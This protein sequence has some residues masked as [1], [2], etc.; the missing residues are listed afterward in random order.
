[1]KRFYRVVDVVT[2]DR[3]FAVTLDGRTVRTPGKLDFAVPH[4]RLAEAVAAEWRRQGERV[5]IGAM[6]LTRFANTA[7][8]LVSGR[9]EEVIRQIAAYAET[10]LVCYRAASPPELVRRQA[11]AWDPLLD[12]L[13]ER[14]GARLAT[15]AGVAPGRQDAP[16]LL[17]VT[18][19]IAGF[20]SFPL[21]AL[22]V[23]ATACGSAVV[24]LAL[25]AGRLDAG[26][27]FAAAHVD[28]AWQAEQWG[29]DPE[30][31][32]RRAAIRAEIEAAAAFFDLCRA[33]AQ[34]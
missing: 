16:Q 26:A 14:Y 17:A 33:E 7:L 34:A 32:R 4:R 10:D 6:R 13:A 24:G 29:A 12:W 27:A 28:E 11:E 18:A 1:M 19:A 22:H 30:A 5:D 21:T 9:R 15:V 2:N 8:D 25:A 31:E 20:D 3:G 23:T